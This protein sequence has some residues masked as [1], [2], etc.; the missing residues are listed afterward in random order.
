MLDD[1]T[2]ITSGNLATPRRTVS[3]ILGLFSLIAASD[4]LARDLITDAGLPPRALEEPDFPVSLEQELYVTQAVVRIT[5]TTCSPVSTLFEQRGLFGIES[6]GVLG[7]AMRHAA[8]AAQALKVCLTYPQ[9]TWGHSRMVVRSSGDL[10]LFCYSMERPVVREASDKDIDILMQHCLVMDLL[11]TLRNIEDIVESPVPPLY[12]HFPFTQPQDW[13]RLQVELPC[14]VK[15][16][17]QQ[18]CLAYPGLMDD[19]PL[20]RAN[21]LLHR[22]YVSIAEKL[23]LMLAEDVG[24]TERVSRWLWAYSPPLKR[25]E[26][27]RQLAMSER[28]F[29]RQLKAEGSSYA[30]L[31]ATVQEE[32]ARTF[33]R[34]RALTVSEIGYRLG[35][36]EPAAFSRAFSKW[37]GLSPLKWR[38]QLS[39]LPDDKKPDNWKR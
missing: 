32:R 10:S 27:A 38:A 33:L 31:L 12:I 34:N 30:Q 24:M 39:E 20:P 1:S 35:Y 19:T 3:G 28:T 14:V 18:T 7:M 15:F 9:L 2:V 21:P 8:T 29:T 5:A 26:I 25:G 11:S 13:Q 17:Q 16:D 23:S 4:K 36:A 37:T 22:T 6:L